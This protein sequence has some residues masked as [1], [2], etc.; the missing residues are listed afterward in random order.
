MDSLDKKILRELQ[1]DLPIVQM[2]FVEIA[3]QVGIEEAELFSRINGLIESGVIRKFG[4][5]IDSKKAGFASTLVAMKVPEKNI[6][7]VAEQISKFES[8]THN[9]ARAT[10]G[11]KTRGLANARD[12]KYNLWFTVIEKNERT[13]E[14][15]LKEIEKKVPHEDMVNLPILR[16]FK[17]DVKFNI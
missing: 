7:K 17:I 6:D 10:A 5:R 15:T 11:R 9:Y 16:K 8:V 3:E 4:L 13:L 1:K 2:P 14:N 12:D